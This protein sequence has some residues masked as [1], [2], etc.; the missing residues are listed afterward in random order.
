MLC[1]CDVM[2]A[3]FREEGGISEDKVFMGGGE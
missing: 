3:L 1:I 2:F